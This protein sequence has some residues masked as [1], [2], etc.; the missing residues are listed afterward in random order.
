MTN[1]LLGSH[2]WC[3]CVYVCVCGLL[4]TSPG[5][6]HDLVALY[7]GITSGSAWGIICGAKGLSPGLLHARQMSSPLCY[8]SSPMNAF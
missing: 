4:L 8:L 7:S 3:L 2:E 1:V 5:C 6:A